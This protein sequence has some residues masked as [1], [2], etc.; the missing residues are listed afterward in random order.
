MNH[1]ADSTTVGRIQQICAEPFDAN[2][3]VVLTNAVYLKST[4]LTAFDQK[5]TQQ[6]PFTLRS[7]QQLTV[8]MMERTDHF[9]YHRGEGFQAVR[10]PYKYGLTALYIVLPDSG[11]SALAL[12]DRIHATEWP[13]PSPAGQNREIHLL[14]PKMHVE[15]QTDLVDP[16][17][18]LGMGIALDSSRADFA[19]L[20]EP[21]PN[22]PPPCPPLSQTSTIASLRC[23]RHWISE[24]KQ[25]TYF[26]V[27]EE[28]TEAAAV[29]VIGM[30]LRGR[31]IQPS[32]I[33]FVVDR[34]FLVALRDERT[35]ALLFVG[36]IARPQ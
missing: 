36:Y 1:W 7:G 2:T 34:P 11:Q 27:N 14:L 5:R 22:R 12:L 10:L 3:K 31:S 9:A 32:P 35:G 6:R 17:K 19:N 30:Q 25:H 15:Q 33:E 18:A 24:I 16:L 28:G 26:D 29:T 4:W 8:P 13:L 20:V 21:R 23:T